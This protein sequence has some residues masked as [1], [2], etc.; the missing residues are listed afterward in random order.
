L[1]R[2]KKLLLILSLLNLFLLTSGFAQQY[3]ID[4][5]GISAAEVDPNMLK[6][7]S[8]LYYTQLCEI[9]NFTVT[10]KRTEDSSK[11]IPEIS[12]FSEDA[13]AFYAEIKKNNKAEDSWTVI[14]HVYNKISA[15]EFS[16][17]KDYDSFYK[18]LMESKSILQTSIKNLIENNKENQ[19]DASYETKTP[20]SQTKISSD[21]LSGNW[22]GENYIDKIVIMRGGR[23]FVIFK[24]GASMNIEIKIV[25][26]KESQSVIITQ[27]GKSNASFFPELP[28]T[29]ALKAAVSAE[30]IVWTLKATDSDT[31]TGKKRTLTAQG[32]SYSYSEIPVTWKRIN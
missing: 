20:S 13:I 2:K 5:F 1:N 28:R 31:L 30:P 6:M 14:L 23:G 7:T 16:Q 26:E 10:D 19:S 17:S 15:K 4:Y 18:I 3:K 11:K 24:N 21:I 27:K 29:T 22:S 9:Q 32:D 12:S 25:T 8:D